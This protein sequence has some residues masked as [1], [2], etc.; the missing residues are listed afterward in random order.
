MNIDSVFQSVNNWI[1]KSMAWFSNST[2]AMD[3]HTAVICAGVFVISALVVYLISVFGMR[4]RTYEEAI[5]E[6]RRRNQEAIQQAKTDKSKKDKKFK[7]WG[8]KSKEKIDE[9]KNTNCD[10]EKVPEEPDIK[11]EPDS[12]N[13]I[14][15][16][17][18][19]KGPSLKKKGRQRKSVVQEKGEEFSQ[20]QSSSDETDEPVSVCN[21]VSASVLTNEDEKKNIPL[22][23]SIRLKE[24]FKSQNSESSV[25]LPDEKLEDVDPVKAVKKSPV[26][27][28][29][30]NKIDSSE[31]CQN[32]E[33][34]EWNETKLLNIIKL[35]TFTEDEVQH[36]TDALSSKVKGNAAEKKKKKK[37]KTQAKK[38]K[39]GRE[40]KE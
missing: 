7:K 13:S 6:Q 25:D 37:K 29:R 28:N 15:S 14:S 2:S 8:K 27:K 36:L 33:N 4:E 9:E 30:K 23:K 22:E 34:V 12:N 19:L 3:L 16:V 17:G 11:P 24:E 21:S 32:S 39:G 26:K 1:H 31:Q 35:T 20:H 10:A 38:G 18:D 5:E 40:G